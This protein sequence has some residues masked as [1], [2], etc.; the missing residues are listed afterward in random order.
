[1]RF[2]R[3]ARFGPFM[4]AVVSVE[5]GELLSEAWD[6]LFEAVELDRNGVPIEY[7]KAWDLLSRAFERDRRGVP[8]KYDTGCIW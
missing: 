6:L 1:M 2:D 8:I 5:A 4:A 3:A 7:D